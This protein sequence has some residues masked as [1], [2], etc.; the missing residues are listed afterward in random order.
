M[1]HVDDSSLELYAL[2][3]ASSF[4]V[5][6]IEEHLLVCAQCRER[7]QSEAEFA[8]IMREAARII[9]T[10]LIATHRTKDGF[11]HLY[12]RQSGPE[13]WTATMRG[14][15]L[16]G[17]VAAQ[18]KLDAIAQCTASFSEMFPEHQCDGACESIVDG[19]A[20]E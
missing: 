19:A 17:G 15:S 11:V 8:T 14:D 7:L 2:G 4:E 3:R 6:A 1:S 5:V 10:E 16:G 20:S 13:S 12:V 9:A 18:S